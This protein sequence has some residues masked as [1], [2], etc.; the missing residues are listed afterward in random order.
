MSECF[1]HLR[2]IS[3]QSW[4]L[5]RR[6]NLLLNW[7]FKIIPLLWTIA[8]EILVP[9]VILYIYTSNT[10]HKAGF[11]PKKL[12]QVYEHNAAQFSQSI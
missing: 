1:S 2:L 3:H 4:V 12:E 7:K 9:A 6:K 10:L 8:L 5:F 11:D